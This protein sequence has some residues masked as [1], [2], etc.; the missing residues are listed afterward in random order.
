MHLEQLLS[1]ISIRS[2]HLPDGR[3][4]IDFITNDSREVRPGA[5]YIAIPGNRFDG[6][7]FLA[8]VAASGA[9]AAMVERIDPTVELPQYEIADA[10]KSWS[11]LSA[12][13]YGQPT[14]EL[15]VHGITAT[16]GKTT[17]AF[18][19]DEILRARGLKTG[20]I[21]TVKIRVGERVTPATMTTPESF[22]LQG[23]FARMRDEGVD[24]V[25]M[26]VSSLAL[27]QQRCA[28]V[29]FNVV[30]FNNFSREHI[31]EHGSE[32]AYW[33]AKAS[34]ITAADPATVTLIN[35]SDLAIATLR[36]KS[37]GQ[38]VTYSLE[39]GIGDLY[40]EDIDL[41]G[42]FP[43]FT[44]VVARELS[45]NPGFPVTIPPGRIPIEL[46][47]PG[48]HTVANA[49]ACAAMAL[50]QG[51]PSQAVQAGLKAFRGLERR[52]ELI[53]DGDFRIIDDHFA[54]T[55]NIEVSLNSLASLRF[56]QL[57]MVY[58]IRGSR[59]VTVNRENV[60][61]LARWVERLGLTE[62]IVTQTLGEVG[63]KDLVRPEEAAVFLEEIAKTPLKVTWRDTMDEALTCALDAA[64][65]GDIIFLAGTQG[66]DKGGRKIL[67]MLA[68][69]EP[70][71]REEI[72]RAVADRICG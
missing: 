65:P 59:G 33:A 11:Q 35:L 34:L 14:R 51:I 9:A 36:G 12:A 52:F 69:R 46:G 54:N 68:E 66:M 53:Y 60:Q 64:G 4:D 48:Q 39:P 19:L 57:H 63:P 61:T 16:N 38:E 7:D 58:A 43:R 13:Y 15:F 24:T 28:D 32:A 30:S 21:G 62:I 49:V 42:D 26:E 31:D 18:M 47:T 25:T 55:N 2:V 1:Q 41:S 23:Y 44:L 8:K 72:L 3:R 22:E 29:A 50:C 17:M 20:L 56:E 67:T 27:A 5:L 10:R 40:P 6:H 70:G 45:V 37:S 71:R